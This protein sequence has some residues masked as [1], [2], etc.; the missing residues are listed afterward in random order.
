MDASVREAALAATLERLGPLRDGLDIRTHA[1]LMLAIAAV[2]GG[3]LH[4]DVVA[5][6]LDCALERSGKRRR[7]TDPYART[8]RNFNIVIALVHLVRHFGL[9]P[10][11]S[12]VSTEKNTNDCACSIV[13]EACRQVGVNITES[14]IAKIW[15]RRAKLLHTINN[16]PPLH[17]LVLHFMDPRDANAD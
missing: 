1:I 8:Y 15:F 3:Q 13:A 9:A 4:A 16:S 7:G 10:T 17:K 11:R 6:L 5:E 14:G 12:A 2:D